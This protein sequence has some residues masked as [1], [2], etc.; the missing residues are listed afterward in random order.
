M[1]EG[2]AAAVD[3]VTLGIESDR[4]LLDPQFELRALIGYVD[5]F[6]LDVK[7]LFG[8][9]LKGPNEQVGGL[10]S[11]CKNTTKL[12]CYLNRMKPCTILRLWS[13]PVGHGKFGRKEFPS[14]S[15]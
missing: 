2:L 14:I 8:T 5:M 9:V 11:V 13:A 1:L 4:C 7:H 6:S 15:S 12:Y 10:G 3:D